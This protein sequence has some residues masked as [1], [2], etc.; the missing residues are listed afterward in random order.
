MGLRVVG[1]V[2]QMDQDH[3]PSLQG[4]CED[5]KGS[6][7]PKATW[8]ALHTVVPLAHRLQFPRL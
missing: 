5:H 1:D 8:S 6:G 4:C 3:S 2:A 7:G